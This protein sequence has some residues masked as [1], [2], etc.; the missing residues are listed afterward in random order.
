[1]GKTTK[2]S[3]FIHHGVDDS[4]PHGMEATIHRILY[5]EGSSYC[6]H[7]HEFFEVFWIEQGEALHLLG[8]ESPLKE[9][10]PTGTLVFVRPQD[11]HAFATPPGTDFTLVNVVFST[12]VI[13]RAHARYGPCLSA[14]PWDQSLSAPLRM[15]LSRSGLE[16]L[17]ACADAM[18]KKKDSLSV[19]TLLLKILQQMVPAEQDS[20][21]YWLQQALTAFTNVEHLALG[22]NGLARL[23]NRSP[24]HLNRT[25][26]EHYGIT[27]TALV[28]VKRLE[29]ASR[30]LVN[31]DEPIVAIALECGFESLTYFY[32]LFQRKFGETPH[33]YRTRHRSAP[34]ASWT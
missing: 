12:E 3:S 34:Q 6:A 9:T 10:F 19:D 2:K 1:M 4:L 21:P 25:V 26:K 33:K 23:A 31:S 7:D 29:H 16:T 24:Q 5:R 32:A 17:S 27:T 28:N 11:V 13:Q 18:I 30:R 22:V 8:L 15:Q 14:W 20:T